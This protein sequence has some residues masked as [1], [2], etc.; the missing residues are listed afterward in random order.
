MKKIINFGIYALS[1]SLF[2]FSCGNASQDKQT[3]HDHSAHQVTAE[4]PKAASTNAIVVES[5]DQMKF[6]TEEIRV[7][8][9][10]NVH[11]T[12]KHVGTMAKEVMGHNFVILK[13]G[14]DVMAFAAAAINAKDSE[15]IPASESASIIAHTKLIG[16]GE[17]TSIDFTL[18]EPG[19]YEYVCSFPGHVAIMKGVIIAE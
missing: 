18:Q 2:L 5:N 9:G 3:D 15:Y 7:K 8:A 1:T 12:L 13:P 14:T 6:D 4:Q 16:G 10:E 19:K 11:L 17:E